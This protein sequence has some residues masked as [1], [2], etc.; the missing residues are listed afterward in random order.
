[1]IRTIGEWTVDLSRRMAPG[2][3]VCLPLYRLGVWLRT[4][5]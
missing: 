1:M 5:G 3:M 2:H 4:R